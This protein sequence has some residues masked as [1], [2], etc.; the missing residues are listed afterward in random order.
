MNFL[1]I[2][3]TDITGGAAIENWR[4]HK[5]LQKGGFGSHVLCGRKY[6]NGPDSSTVVPGKHSW[7]LNKLAGQVYDSVGLQAMG[8]PANLFIGASKWLQK[9]ADIVILRNLHGWYFSLELL[10]AIA[11]QAPII[12]R[13]PDMWALTGH[14]AYSYDCERWQTGCGQCPYLSEY[15]ALG[16][17]TTRFLWKRKMTIY[18]K[19]KGKMVFVSPSSWL[20]KKIRESPLT[21]DFRCEHIPTAVDLDVFKP[22][23]KK[24]ARKILGIGDHAKVIMFSGA[25]LQDRRKGAD[26]FLRVI[27]KLSRGNLSQA[28][29]LLVGS[30]ADSLDTKGMQTIRINFVQDDRFLALCY[31][32]ADVY[33]SMSRADNLPNTLV[34]AVACGV[35]GVTLNTGGCP[36]IIQH[37]RNGYVADN[38]GQ[39]D[40]MLSQLLGC[41]EKREEFARQ[42]RLVAEE[43]FSMDN[44]VTA[45]VRLA[46]ETVSARRNRL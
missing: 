19:L 34:E 26:L 33:A 30:G 24:E 35:P 44:Q 16:I 37:Q 29:L 28:V 13:L 42:S 18:E 25:N 17:D 1:H 7:V 22:G 12:W 31:N 3:T 9:W 36:E 32:A 39:M 40:V 23:L 5:A 2:H 10:P 4:L 11:R 43:K 8:Y 6:A 27:E 45:F 46:E 21:R 38:I 15:P 20:Q 14:C 41:D